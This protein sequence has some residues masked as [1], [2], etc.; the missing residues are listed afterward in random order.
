MQA[1]S[2]KKNKRDAK[3][4]LME[5]GRGEKVLQL[6]SWL[7][8]RLFS[9]SVRI[10]DVLGDFYGPEF[11]LSRAAWRTMAIVANNPGISAKEICR[12]GGLDQFSVSRAVR[13][14]VELGFAERLSGRSDKRYAAVELS[15]AGWAAFVQIS[16]LASQLDSELMAAVTAEELAALD[17]VLT[18]LDN[19][20]AG[21]LARGWRCAMSKP[22]V[23]GQEEPE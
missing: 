18:K 10:A 12:A 8:Y 17:R 19:A 21:V 6:G 1:N 14:L 15:E 16:E 9:I 22:D 3:F 5:G 2:N 11:G 13:Q 20:S 23:D 4:Q 7:P